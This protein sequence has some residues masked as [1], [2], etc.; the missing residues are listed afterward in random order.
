MY[1]VK[2]GTKCIA[3]WRLTILQGG[4]MVSL[5]NKE[6]L[7]PDNLSVCLGSSMYGFYDFG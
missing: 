5:D 6:A 2:F 3:G 1:M 4:S 7:K